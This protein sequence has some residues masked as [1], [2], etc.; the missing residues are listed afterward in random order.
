MFGQ[1]SK[2]L[3]ISILPDGVQESSRILTEERR[4]VEAARLVFRSN[5]E[6]KGNGFRT[7][8]DVVKDTAPF[9][10]FIKCQQSSC[11]YIHLLQLAGKTLSTYLDQQKQFPADRGDEVSSLFCQIGVSCD[12]RNR[13]KSDLSSTCGKWGRYWKQICCSVRRD[14]VLAQHLCLQGT[15]TAFQHLA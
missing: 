15:Q 6:K 10:V 4:K 7:E 2:Q 3:K 12:L 1:L 11:K 9:L 13:H 5:S 14:V 8:I